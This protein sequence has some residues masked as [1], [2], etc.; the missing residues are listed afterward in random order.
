MSLIKSSLL[1]VNTCTA[2]I[3]GPHNHPGYAGGAPPHADKDG[4][5]GGCPVGYAEYRAGYR[6]AGCCPV[7]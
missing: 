5:G 4:A 6:A 1:S 3:V 2:C 7:G